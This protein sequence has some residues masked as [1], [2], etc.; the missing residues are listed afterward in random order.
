MPKGT[1]ENIKKKNTVRKTKIKGKNIEETKD[2][3][4]SFDEEIVIGLKRLDEPEIISRKGNKKKTNNIN[5]GRNRIS[6]SKNDNSRNYRKGNVR[7]NRQSNK[8]SNNDGIIDI[9]DEDN[10]IIQSK[11]MQNYEDDLTSLKRRNNK[12]QQKANSSQGMQKANNRR[13]KNVQNK[14]DTKKNV[15][16]NNR[17]NYEDRRFKTIN[18]NAPLSKEEIQKIEKSKKKR[19]LI[20]KI[21]KWLT[22]LAI[23]IGGTIYAM[24]SPIFNIKEV[25]VIGNSKIS[26]E[27]IISLSGITID[28]NMFSFRT[29]NVRESIK[30]NAYIDT[31][32]IHRDLPDKISLVVTERKTT[33]MI[34]FGNAYAYINNQGY[35]LEIT[36]KEEAVPIITGYETL[37][38]NI[39]EG[40][41]LNTEDL[42]KLNDVLKIM[43]AASSSGNN[44]KNLITKIDISDKSNYILNLKKQK[45]QI[46]FGDAT[47]LS[48]KMLWIDQILGEEKKSEGILYLNMDLN[49]DRPYFREKI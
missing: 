11:Y 38:E 9:G 2:D 25:E 35:I 30:N 42:E 45:K 29:S 17:S 23:I 31:V 8:K 41:R 27:T 14:K 28:Q 1:K 6:S 26:S 7:N 22:L 49:T 46:Y 20:L 33:Y 37:D 40:N 24:L 44:L 4:F 5:N 39:Q 43:E 10:V 16:R 47:N 21:I 13:V 34:K 12:I 36:D 15:Q 3:K 32:E 18:I 19:K 48:T